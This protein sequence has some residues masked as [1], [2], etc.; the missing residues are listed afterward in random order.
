MFKSTPIINI[1]PSNIVTAF[2]D[3]EVVGTKVTRHVRFENLLVK[4]VAA[5]DFE[6]Q[7][8]PGQAFIMLDPAAVKAVGAGVGKRS[9]N[10]EDY[11]LRCHR[12]QVGA[13]LR[14]ELAE[15]ASGV[16]VVVYTAEAYAKD[17]EVGAEEVAR[18]QAEGATHVLVAVLAFAGPPSP[19]TPERFTHNLAGGNNEAMGWDAETIRQKAGEI[20]AYHSEWCVVAD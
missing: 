4:A 11:V 12:G 15:P 2:Q 5:T 9:Q 7:Q 16:A 14:R 18:V 20:S 1:I 10:P 17:P 13:F 19:L 3:E 6:Q 8:V